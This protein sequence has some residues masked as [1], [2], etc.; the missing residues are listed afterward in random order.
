MFVDRSFFS[1]LG[2]E[3]NI[4][5]KNI[6]EIIKNKETQIIQ[7]PKSEIDKMEDL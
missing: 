5:Y 4:E 6:I 2:N 1:N 7:V 3:I